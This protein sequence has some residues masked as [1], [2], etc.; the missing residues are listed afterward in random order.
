MTC[1]LAAPLSKRKRVESVRQTEG[2]VASRCLTFPSAQTSYAGC[3][4]TAALVHVHRRGDGVLKAS[5]VHIGAVRRS[6]LRKAINGRSQQASIH[7][8]EKRQL[9]MQGRSS[10]NHLSGAAA[11]GSARALGGSLHIALG[12]CCL[13]PSNVRIRQRLCQLRPLGT[14]CPIGPVQCLHKAEG[15]GAPSATEATQRRD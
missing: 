14:Q 10:T 12:T 5:V 3:V 4:L 15:R 2:A 13:P 6:W 9:E 11:R 8:P 1:P 7:G